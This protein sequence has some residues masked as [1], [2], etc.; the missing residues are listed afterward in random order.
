[1]QSGQLA[2]AANAI[3]QSLDYLPGGAV[4]RVGIV[5]YD[6]AVHFYHIKVLKRKDRDR[7]T[8]VAK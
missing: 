6:S 4:A 7:F 8:V 3:A 1:M 5:T 2:V